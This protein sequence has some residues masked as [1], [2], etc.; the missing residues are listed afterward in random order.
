MVADAEA[1]RGV[2]TNMASTAIDAGLADSGFNTV[3]SPVSNVVQREVL[4]NT[5]GVKTSFNVALR[6]DPSQ[7][8][9]DPQN[10]CPCVNFC[11]L[12]PR[13]CRST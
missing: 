12:L 8:G 9:D 1:A 6:V 11:S 13:L 2:S 7:V 10:S 5:T 3:S 4:V